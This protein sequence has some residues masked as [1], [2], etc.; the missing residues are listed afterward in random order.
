MIWREKTSL[1]DVIDEWPT[2]ADRDRIS[3]YTENRLLRHDHHEQVFA[4]VQKQ[5]E[6]AQRIEAG[7]K[8]AALTYVPLNALALASK[9]TS[10]DL[11]LEPPSVKF[12]ERQDLDKAFERIS[13]ASRLDALLLD[14]VDGGTVN[15]DCALKVFRGPDNQVR[16]DA[17]DV[18][19]VFRGEDYFPE[20]REANID[21]RSTRFPFIATPVRCDDGSWVV[22]L[23]IHEPGGVLYRAARWSQHGEGAARECPSFADEGELGAMVDVATIWPTVRDY[24]TSLQ[25]PT[26]FIVHNERGQ[27]PFWGDS[28]YSRGVKAMQDQLNFTLSELCSH[29]ENLMA[30][31]FLVLDESQRALVMKRGAPVAP[32][33][34]TDFGRSHGA[35]TAGETGEL[36]TITRRMLRVIFESS[37]SSGLTRFLAEQPQFEGAFKLIEG[38]WAA[39]ERRLGV[40]LDPLF[41]TPAAPE[42]GRAMR[43]QRHRDQRRVARK[44]IRYSAL[45]EVFRAAVEWQAGSSD[46]PAPSIQWADSLP[47]SDQE[48]AEIIAQRLGGRASISLKTA[49]QRW[50][51]LSE[52]QASGEAEA[53]ARENAERTPAGLPSSLFADTARPADAAAAAKDEGAP[54]EAPP[55]LTE[56]E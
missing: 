52:E 19:M 13:S 36:P 30:S 23:E 17:V 37:Q 55:G 54:D 28:D 34:G 4:R 46:V 21:T 53:I 11:F 3:G 27:S 20:Y 51:G 47:V 49:L 44:Q 56:V 29:A 2:P 26:L 5:L 22:V 35:A 32:G 10:E 24:E 41:T 9:A 31:G 40:T 15:G 12:G 33:Q 14:E 50:D 8:W 39:L 48:K 18:S 1:R 7:R 45:A 25:D 42:S 6:T 43:L 38:L 16:V